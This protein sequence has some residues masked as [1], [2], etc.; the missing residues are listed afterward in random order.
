MNEHTLGPFVAAPE[1]LEALAAVVKWW[2][3]RA[4]IAKAKVEKPNQKENRK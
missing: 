2:D 4:A 1:L 3:A